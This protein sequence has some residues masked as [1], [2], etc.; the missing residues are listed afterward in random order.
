MNP[1]QTVRDIYHNLG[2][3][4]RDNRLAAAAYALRRMGLS[5][6]RIARVMG[7]RGHSTAHGCVKRAMSRPDIIAA[8]E[9]IE[10]LCVARSRSR[11]IMESIGAPR[12]KGRGNG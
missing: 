11:Q 9:E 5:Y 8:V 10:R 2:W 12:R 7:W 3:M 4:K 6:P 1:H